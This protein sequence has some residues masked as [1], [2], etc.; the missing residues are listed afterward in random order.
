V[1][2]LKEYDTHA[3]ERLQKALARVNE[4]VIVARAAPRKPKFGRSYPAQSS[5]NLSKA[6]VREASMSTIRSFI[7]LRNERVSPFEPVP[8]V[9]KKRGWRTSRNETSCLNSSVIAGSKP[10]SLTVVVESV[11]GLKDAGPVQP[12]ISPVK[13]RG[14]GTTENNFPKQPKRRRP[15]RKRPEKSVQVSKGY[16]RRHKAHQNVREAADQDLYKQAKTRTRRVH[17]SSKLG[18]LSA[19][20]RRRRRIRKKLTTSRLKKTGHDGGCLYGLLR[21]CVGAFRRL[22][23]PRASTQ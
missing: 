18:S 2:D 7:S 1:P 19:Q 22:F 17:R 11:E 23:D 4:D 15:R 14:D 20:V 21:V 13:D 8:I 12:H 10:P 6:V 9:T 16:P 5:I 3:R